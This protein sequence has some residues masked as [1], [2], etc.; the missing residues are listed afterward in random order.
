[1]YIV[2]L[3]V[4]LI[5]I[6][7]I[8]TFIT[9]RAQQNVNICLDPLF[10]FVILPRGQEVRGAALATMLSNLIACGFFF[11]LLPSLKKRNSVLNLRF[12]PSAW[13]DRTVI[14]VLLTGLPACLM[15]LLENIS[16]AVLDHLMAYGGIAMQA[17]I[18]VA[19][20]IN[21]LAHSMVRGMAQ[22]LLPL[23]AYNYGCGNTTRMRQSV[24]TG[25][26]LSVCLATLCMAGNFLFARPLVNIFTASG[27][28]Q[29][30]GIRFLRILCLGCPFSAFGYVIISY[31]QAVNQNRRS[32]LLA[33]LRKG[34]LDIP[35]MLLLYWWSGVESTVWATPAADL[36]CCG[37]AAFLFAASLRRLQ[38]ASLP[39]KG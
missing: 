37:A 33:M 26:K 7:N 13:S 24:I 10:M 12:R 6:V 8:N 35:M 32:F 16:Y 30:A 4:L 18:G 36:F 20:K 28:S 15:T 14:A 19:K 23:I 38:Q 2:S 1:M 27:P 9:I 29:I 25:L 22:G 39:Q 31:M 5:K 3:L 11:A 17:G 34:L 21:M